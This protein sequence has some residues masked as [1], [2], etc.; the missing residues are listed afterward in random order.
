MKDQTLSIFKI[1]R[2]LRILIK[3]LRAQNLLNFE[4]LSYKYTI[5]FKKSEQKELILELKFRKKTA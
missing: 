5:G 2:L 4:R 3:V 1:K